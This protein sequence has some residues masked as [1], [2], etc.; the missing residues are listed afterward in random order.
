MALN[1][2]GGWNGG[3]TVTVPCTVDIEITPDSV[4]AWVDLEGV[5]VGPGDEVII[6]DAPTSL[7]F[8]TQH[9]FHRTAIVVHAGPLERLRAQ[10]A[11]YLELTE[12]YEVGFSAGRPS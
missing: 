2:N 1:W 8:G 7:P 10:L 11:G 5:E 6:E 12:L 4:H 9:F 3:G